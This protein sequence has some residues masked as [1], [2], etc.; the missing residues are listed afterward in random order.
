MRF[1]CLIY[2][3]NNNIGPNYT[4]AYVDQ[5]N[6]IVS[7][8]ISR[9][10]DCSYPS[11]EGLYFTVSNFF[12]FF[13]LTPVLLAYAFNVIF[14]TLYTSTCRL[15]VGN[16]IGI[17]TKRLWYFIIFAL[18]VFVHRLFV[19]FVASVGDC[20]CAAFYARFTRSIH[21]FCMQPFTIL[22][23]R[24]NMNFCNKRQ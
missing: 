19:L 20:Y 4:D 12:S 16:P 5:T 1:F 10:I 11:N 6:F 14:T 8:A 24:T 23:I 21:Y 22:Y 9:S 2:R 18:Y 17:H 7:I 13:F 3:K 15:H